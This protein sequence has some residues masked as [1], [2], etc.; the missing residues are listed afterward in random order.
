MVDSL[1]AAMALAVS[2]VAVDVTTA[3]ES[4]L[5]FDV[6]GLQPR[7]ASPPTHA[8]KHPM[9]ASRPRKFVRVPMECV[10][11]SVIFHS[12][13]GGGFSWFRPT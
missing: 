11:G 12:C 10:I 7:R 4:A 1:G 13:V 5:C 2:P 6:P 3:V 9:P 8:M